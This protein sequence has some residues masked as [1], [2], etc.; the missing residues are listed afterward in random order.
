MRPEDLNSESR[1]TPPDGIAGEVEFIEH[2]GAES[3][4]SVAT[5][6][7]TWTVRLAGAEGAQAGQPVRLG[8]D[9][10]RIHLFAGAG[11]QERLL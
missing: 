10:D 7:A 1:T 11:A 8:L 5:S 3:Y 6:C 2:T 9:A 4:A